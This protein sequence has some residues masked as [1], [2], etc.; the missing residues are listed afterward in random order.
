M[1]YNGQGR[2]KAELNAAKGVSVRLGH[3]F[4]LPNGRLFE[5]GAHA[6]YN[7]F[8]ATSSGA[9]VIGGPTS[10]TA[11]T[12]C[13]H[14]L[15]GNGGCQVIDER[16]NAYFWTPPQPWG[17]MAEY[18]LGRGPERDEHGI[19]TP[20]S[21]RGGYVQG[22]YTWRYSYTGLLTPYVRWGEYYPLAQAGKL[23]YVLFQLAPWVRHGDA[24]LDYLASLPRRLPGWAIAVEFRNASWIPERTDEVLRFLADHGLAFVCVDAPWQPF[25][26]AATVPGWVVFR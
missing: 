9:V 15:Q 5:V 20:Q 7:Q 10:T 1:V 12:R 14:N 19:L 18:T 8:V 25:I 13:Y 16:V 23:G 22:N 24:T 3:P 2:N 11:N 4:E 17:I 21:L 26:P 6:Y